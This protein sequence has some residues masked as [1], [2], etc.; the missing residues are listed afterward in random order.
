MRP[1][2]VF[3]QLWRPRATLVATRALSQSCSSLTACSL[4]TSSMS[5]QQDEEDLDLDASGLRLTSLSDITTRT[6]LREGEGSEGTSLKAATRSIGVRTRHARKAKAATQLPKGRGKRGRGGGRGARRGREGGR[7]RGRMRNA[8][9]HGEA[10]QIGTNPSARSSP[11]SPSV[12]VGPQGTTDSD[13]L[14]SRPFQQF[15]AKQTSS[16]IPPLPAQSLSKLF[17]VQASHC[18]NGRV[19]VPI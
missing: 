10:S 16:R 19:E 13:R 2:A 9:E 5:G 15:L 3:S 12:D 18:F 4:L 11:A 14:R 7:G 6:L 17:N 8:E 1:R